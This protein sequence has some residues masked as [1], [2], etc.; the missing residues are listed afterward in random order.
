MPMPK[1][2]WT[3]EARQQ[4]DVV[5]AELEAGAGASPGKM[6]GMPTLYLAGKAF[7]GLWGEGMVFKLAGAGHAD[8]LALE[9]AR[10]FDPSGRGRPMR[11]WVEVPVA[12]AAQWSRLAHLAAHS[13]D[14]TA[15][16]PT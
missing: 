4:Y 10:L 1:P 13:L 3:D 12:Q 6:M 9:G 15:S 2:R 7:A 14:G 11:A 16:D 8:A 5:R